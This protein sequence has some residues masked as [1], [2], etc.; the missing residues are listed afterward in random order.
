MRMAHLVCRIGDDPE[1]ILR[2][3]AKAP[4][5][6]NFFNNAIEDDEVLIGQSQAAS[7]LMADCLPRRSFS[8]S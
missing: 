7:R 1:F 8:I 4:I 5:R 2:M 6:K 3:D